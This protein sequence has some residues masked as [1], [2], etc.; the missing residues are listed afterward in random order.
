MEDEIKL[1]HSPSVQFVA[2]ITGLSIDSAYLLCVLLNFAMVWDWS[3]GSRRK[4][5][6]ACFA[7]A[8]RTSKKPCKRRARRARRRI[9][10]WLISNPGCRGS[11]TEIAT[12]R[13]SC[14][15]RSCG[16]RGANQSRSGR[17]RAQ[18]RGISGTGN[19]CRDQSGPPRV[20]GLCRRSGGFF[21]GPADSCGFADRSGVGP[22][23]L[24]KSLAQQSL[25]DRERR[26][27]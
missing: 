20:D 14:R 27:N 4:I 2:R 8:L 17:R 7:I 19:C 9:G 1:K 13:A 6:Q 23:V 24:P 22:R 5:C 16:G 25:A 10:G 21:G 18:N 3:S 15:K 11:T 12:M 26:G